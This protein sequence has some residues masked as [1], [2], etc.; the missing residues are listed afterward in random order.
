MVSYGLLAELDVN[1]KGPGDLVDATDTLD[2]RVRVKGPGWSRAE[3]VA[4]YANG[5]RLRDEKIATGTKAGVKW[6]GAW[7]LPRPAHDV[8]LVAIATG[9]G[10]DAPYWRTA[11]PY[12]PTSIEFTS[13]V[14]GVSGAVFVDADGSRAFE[15]AF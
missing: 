15:S 2:V 1:G 11:K 9:P 13:Y 8:H 12:Q 4:L 3:R 6:E 7:R 10:I 14:L 5:V